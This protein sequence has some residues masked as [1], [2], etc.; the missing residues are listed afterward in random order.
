M[1]AKLILVGGDH[2]VE[3]LLSSFNTLGRHPDNSI[4][5]L[6]RIVSKEHCRITLS[7]DGRYLIRDI[8]SLN[9]SFVNGEKITERQLQH[10]DQ[11]SLGNT[12]YR[13]VEDRPED[14]LPLRKVTMMGDQVQ[15]QVQSTLNAASRFLP[16]SA[17]K[18]INELRKDYEKLRIAHELSQKLSLD[19]DLDELLQK[20]VDETFQ[21]IK[22]D[23]AVI[24]L[25]NPDTADLEPRYVRQKRDEEIRL[26]RSIL[27][28][29]KNKKRAVL[30]SDALVDERFKAAKS[31]IMQGIRST[32]CVPL[33]FNEKLLGAIHVDSMLATGA[34]TEK[35]LLLFSGLATQAAIAIEN[36]RLAKKIEDE[37]TARAQFQRLLSPNLVDQIVSGQLA[38]DQGGARREVT[39]LFADIRGFTSMSE[40]H[41]PEE[42]V[43]TLNE[44]FEVMVDVLFRHGG[45]LDKYVGD[46][47]IGLFGAPVELPDAPLRSIRCA[48]DMMRALEEFNRSREAQRKE[49]VAI[50]IGINTGAVIAGA[51]G[52]TQTLQYT[53]I[54][55]AVNTASRLCGMAKP[56]EILISHSTIHLAGP[57]VIHEPRQPVLVK[58]KRDPLPVFAAK[59]IRETAPPSNRG[60]TPLL[61]I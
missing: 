13:F 17:I 59:G 46:E 51:I 36:H 10:G 38:L 18:D 23:R 2:P 49:P 25:I 7:A 29:V 6:D 58:G 33:L 56:G 4:Q 14:H 41:T 55:D 15:S 21:L 24:L 35:D 47:I 22:A 57:H 27:D 42:M 60:N 44:Y 61:N 19:T 53:V 9:G 52:S 31:I 8:G 16:A 28:E 34:F 48:L 11:I 32:M 50:G 45:T 12:T 54:G 39:M 1:A 5:V 40:R 43:V 30:S 3:H 26:S 20:I 37:A